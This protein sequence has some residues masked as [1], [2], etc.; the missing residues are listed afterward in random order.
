MKIWILGDQGLVGIYRVSCDADRG[1]IWNCPKSEGILGGDGIF[2][3]Q[4]LVRSMVSHY[5]ILWRSTF[6]SQI[7]VQY[8]GE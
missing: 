1:Q 6:H 2:S 4:L 7:S 5:F 3:L 8:L